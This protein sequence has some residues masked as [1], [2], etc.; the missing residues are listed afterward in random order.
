[1]MSKGFSMNVSS[2]TLLEGCFGS[3]HN[4]SHSCEKIEGSYICTCPNEWRLLS[5][6]VT[7]ISPCSP[8]VIELF[9][10]TGSIQFNC[11]NSTWK[12]RVPDAKMVIKL[13]LVSMTLSCANTSGSGSGFIEVFNGYE[14]DQSISMVKACN[15]SAIDGPLISS[16]NEISIKYSPT[17]DNDTVTLLY[18]TVPSTNDGQLQDIKLYQIIPSSFFFSC[19]SSYF[20]S[21]SVFYLHLNVY[22]VN[23]PLSSYSC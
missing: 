6:K 15:V 7:C 12:I 13:T 3:L 2:L 9:N 4:C 11:S 8:L 19:F 21:L 20:L 16:V 10:S 5:D 1:M 17:R 18:E 23:I 14:P 22:V